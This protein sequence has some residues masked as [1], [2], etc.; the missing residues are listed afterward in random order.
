MMSAFYILKA[1][2]RLFHRIIRPLCG[3]MPLLCLFLSLPVSSFAGSLAGQPDMSAN[4]IVSGIISFTHWP[5]KSGLPR[6][7]I[8]SSARHISFSQQ[9]SA[10]SPAKTFDVSYLSNKVNLST[11]QCDAI[12]FG[13]ES[14]QQQSEILQSV[15]GRPTLSIAENNPD[16]TLGAVFCLL[17][18]QKPPAFSVNLDSLSRS[19]VRVNPDVLLL[20]RKG[21]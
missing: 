16:C 1:Y 4:R 5:G 13:T 7:C 17:M 10:T 3:V 20:S 19:G 21:Y 15:R 8:F 14:P 6:L 2:F 12:Y 18:N 9:L 11:L